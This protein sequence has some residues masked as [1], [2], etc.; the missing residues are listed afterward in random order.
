[1]QGVF[2]MNG[3]ILIQ[4]VFNLF[5]IA[6]IIEAAVMAIFQMSA[7]KDL[8]SSLP[9]QT[10]RDALILILAAVLCYKV[11]ILTLFKGTGIKLPYILDTVVSAL[12]LTRMTFFIRD[13][14][15]RIKIER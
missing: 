2:P 4:N 5:V 11:P 12:V 7:M 3:E 1:M 6:I 13:F 8:E 9:F 14:F 15:S 10:A